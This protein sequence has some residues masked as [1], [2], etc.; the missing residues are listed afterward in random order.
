MRT[1]FTLLTIVLLAACA[2]EQRPV[3][4]SGAWEFRGLGL[5]AETP[6]TSPGPIVMSGEHGEDRDGKVFLA[7]CRATDRADGDL[8]L[9]LQLDNQ[10]GDRIELRLILPGDQLPEEGEASITPATCPG[11]FSFEARRQIYEAACILD[12]ADLDGTG[13]E[14]IINDVLVDRDTSSVSVRF[15]CDAISDSGFSSVCDIGGAGSGDAVLSFD[16]CEGL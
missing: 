14:C 9:H 11:G 7:R 12:P 2:D 16:E 4:G 10:N 3:F 6:C 8:G 5:N 15:R 1:L 13:G